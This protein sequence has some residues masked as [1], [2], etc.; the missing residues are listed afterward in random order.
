M[1]Y[2]VSGVIS[3][4]NQPEIYEGSLMSQVDKILRR[5]TEN[6]KR[7]VLVSYLHYPIR[8][9]NIHCVL[10]PVFLLLFKSINTK[11]KKTC[12]RR[13]SKPKN[14]IIGQLTKS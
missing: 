7:F 9:Q 8:L 13:L 1:C 14:K 4:C 2:I 11:L 12:A 5:K 3:P 6:G 10:C